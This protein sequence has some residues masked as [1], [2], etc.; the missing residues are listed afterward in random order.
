MPA[1]SGPVP[2][3]AAGRG[4]GDAAYLAHPTRRG[5]R[6]RPVRAGTESRAGGAGP[7]RRH[8]RAGAADVAHAAAHLHNIEAG[9]PGTRPLHGL[10]GRAARRR[11]HGWGGLATSCSRARRASARPVWSATW[12]PF[13]AGSGF[14]VLVGRCHEGDYAPALWPWVTIVRGLPGADDAPELAPL[15]AGS[16]TPDLSGGSGM[17]MFDAVAGLLAQTA[18][19]PAAAGRAGGHPLGRRDDPPAAAAPGVDALPP[20]RSSS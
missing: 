18:R 4:T 13:A 19:D 5:P 10:R 15:L 12:P 6:G 1:G 20:R 16:S 8:R 11:V 7:G 2:V 17:R 3:R 9:H 14:A